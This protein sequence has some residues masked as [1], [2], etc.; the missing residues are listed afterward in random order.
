MLLDT[1][2]SPPA[3]LAKYRI[4][5]RKVAEESWLAYFQNLHDIVHSRILVSALPEQPNR[6]LN[7]L[8]AQLCFLAFTQ[9]GYFRLRGLFSLS[10]S[11]PIC[12][13]K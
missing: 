13:S 4:L 7:D 9:A 11:S 12:R 2:E 3:H 10:L 5:A 6:R 8:L 1:R